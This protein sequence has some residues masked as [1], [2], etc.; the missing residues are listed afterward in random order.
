MDVVRI[1]YP[2]R[3]CSICKYYTEFTTLIQMATLLMAS[4][5]TSLGQ[6]TTTK[7]VFAPEEII[8]KPVPNKTRG[9]KS[10]N[11]RGPK[12]QPQRGLGVA[13][14]ERLRLHDRW[15][16]MTEIPPLAQQNEPDHQLLQYQ[17]TP[18]LPFTTVTNPFASVPVHYGAANY[19]VSHGSQ[20]VINGTTVG[21]LGQM[22]GNRGGF[23]GVNGGGSC[24]AINGGFLVTNQVG[25]MVETYEVGAQGSTVLT[26]NSFETSKELSSMPKLHCVSDRC[27]VSFKKKRWN[28]M[29]NV[30]GSD[31]LGLSSAQAPNF[32]TQP[33]DFTTI[34]SSYGARNLDQ[35]VE[36]MAVHW[37]GNSEGGRVF[38][39]YEF[40]PAA[41]K[42]GRVIGT[43]SKG[44]EILPREASV[45][46]GG[47][48]SSI[49]P[50]TYGDSSSNSIDLSLKL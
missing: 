40:F 29:N 18:I 50:T 11:S 42:N 9:R 38:M 2:P 35:H 41:G 21:L 1:I 12:K 36:V 4:D 37:K 23:C 24:S 5:Q 48:A 6:E 16:K 33:S 34:A 13:Q 22:I 45:A 17:N 27:N 46:E 32:I 14:L 39:E 49:T 10:S 26:G 19:G 15:K 8:S 3:E 31:F 43:C 7:P 25:Q 44:L 30:S 28:M 47:E 20:P